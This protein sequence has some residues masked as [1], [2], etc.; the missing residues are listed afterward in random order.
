ME[1]QINR[2]KRDK[3]LHELFGKSAQ[4]RRRAADQSDAN[5]EASW[6]VL[7]KQ[8]QSM[9][10]ITAGV[11]RIG[12]DLCWVW[13]SKQPLALRCKKLRPVIE[14]NKGSTEPTESTA[15]RLLRLSDAAKRAQGA[16]RGLPPFQAPSIPR[17]PQ[18]GFFPFAS[19]PPPLPPPPTSMPP[20]MDTNDEPEKDPPS[21]AE[22][23]HHV[24]LDMQPSTEEEVPDEQPAR[25]PKRSVKSVTMK[26]DPEVSMELP[27]SPPPLPHGDEDGIEEDLGDVVDR[28]TAVLTD[29]DREALMASGGMIDGV[30]DKAPHELCVK[31]FWQSLARP[32]KVEDVRL[33]FPNLKSATETKDFL[34]QWIAHQRQQGRT[35]PLFSPP[36]AAKTR[37]P[38]RSGQLPGGVAI[39]DDDEKLIEKQIE[40]IKYAEWG[41]WRTALAVVGREHPI[42][43]I[44]RPDPELSSVQKNLLLFIGI[45]TFLTVSALFLG[46]VGVDSPEIFSFL[47]FGQ[48]F[49]LTVRN[50]IIWILSLFL[51]IPVPLI[52][53][54][55][56]RKKVPTPPKYKKYRKELN[57]IRAA[58]EKRRRTA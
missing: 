40:K 33:R 23:R 32:G 31:I 57:R 15:M 41:A 19:G 2:M 35:S 14:G 17:P 13:L 10:P 24:A 25:K 29:D 54:K 36:V 22:P 44:L 16:D 21:A 20:S 58:N 3:T 8:Y 4:E 52:I 28:D 56:F 6:T 48:P 47:L 30:P 50:L 46:A 34:H 37:L 43:Q 7:S 53:N 49:K 51:S 45:Y 5:T 1:A 42:A 18:T 39:D 26:I 27:K 38:S 11:C 12:A 55:L 9:V